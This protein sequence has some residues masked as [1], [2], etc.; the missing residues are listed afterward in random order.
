MDEVKIDRRMQLAK[1]PHTTYC[2]GVYHSMNVMIK[3]EHEK[4]S[5]S[6]RDELAAIRYLRYLTQ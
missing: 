1:G 6:L 3:Y 2:C 5:T 4:E